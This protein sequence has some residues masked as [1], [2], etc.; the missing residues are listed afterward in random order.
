[1]K[2]RRLRGILW[3]Y[4][5]VNVGHLESVVHIL[6]QPSISGISR[7]CKSIPLSSSQ[8]KL[9][10]NAVSC[11]RSIY[12]DIMCCL[13]GIPVWFIV[14]DRNPKYISWEGSSKNKGLRTRV[15][16]ILEAAQSSETLRPSSVIFFFSKGL[17]DVVC[18]KFQHEFPAADLRQTF[19]CF[20]CSFC[21]E[22]EAEWINVLS[23]SYEEACVLKLEINDKSKDSIL[24]ST[25]GYI[26]R[27]I[28]T[29]LPRQQDNIQGTPTLGESLCSLISGLKCCLLDMEFSLL[30][31]LSD[32][33]SL[34]LVNFDTTSLIAIASGISN[35]GT[36]K[37]LATPET[38][39]RSQFK[40][41]SEFVIAQVNS[42]IL[43]PIHEELCASTSGKGGIICESV[44]SE[45]QELVSMCGGPNEKLRANYIL[46]H[47]R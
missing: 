30:K 5:S 41:N 26:V 47:L 42:E 33:H 32:D 6:E 9:R 17:N 7:V 44:H 16:K 43:K 29:G 25:T 10:A 37:L 24:T 27:P 34:Q 46:K 31:T 22:S 13:D 1:M 15:E 14:S 2:Q 8:E 45:F 4:N 11:L 21:E 23:R 12:V 40:S 36:N 39:L 35:G 20:D 3:L 38:K 28:P 18:K 19:P